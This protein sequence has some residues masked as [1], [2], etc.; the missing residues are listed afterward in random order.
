MGADAIR[1]RQGRPDP[2]QHQSGLPFVRTRI[3]AQQSRLQRARHRRLAS[4]P[5]TMSA[6]CASW[7]RKSTAHAGQTAAERL[8]H[9]RR[10][11]RIGAGR[12]ARLLRFDDV[13]R[14]RRRTPS[15]AA[16]GHSPRSCNST[17]RSTSSSP[18]APPALPKARRSPTTTSSTTAFSS[19]R[20]AAH[21]SATASASRCRSIIASAW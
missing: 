4:S 9:L 1:H 18:A 8:P 14:P 16:C 5:A 12:Q 21:A 11:I 19:A 17:I 15:R 6:C 7:R 2:R 20:D 10:V 13:A 3:R